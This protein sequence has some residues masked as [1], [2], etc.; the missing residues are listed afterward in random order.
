MAFL[1]CDVGPQ[2]GAVAILRVRRD[3]NKLNVSDYQIYK[4]TQSTLIS[5]P[6]IVQTA[7]RSNDL[8]NIKGLTPHAIQASLSTATGETELIKVH[9]RHGEWSPEET[10]TILSVIVDAYL[11]EIVRKERLEKVEA[12]TMLRT[13][14]SHTYDQVAKKTDE[15][16]TLAKQLGSADSASTT[17]ERDAIRDHL[18]LL[19]ERLIDLRLSEEPASE[20]AQAAHS[21]KRELLERLIEE[22][23]VK[24]KKYDGTSGQLEAKKDDLKSLRRDMQAVSE[25]MHQLEVELDGPATVQ[26]IQ[27]PIYQ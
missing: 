27:A 11:K 17:V 10:E 19:Q 13:R 25:E 15:I 4:E 26:V 22:Q 6:F 1:G 12:L 8:K 21:A 9:L 7:I 18:G 24:L 3:A 2:R 16:A 5:S 20:D 23:I 14:Y